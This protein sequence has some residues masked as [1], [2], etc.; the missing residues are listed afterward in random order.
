MIYIQFSLSVG[1]QFFF[2]CCCCEVHKAI[3]IVYLFICL[4]FKDNGA[5]LK[6]AQVCTTGTDT[7]P[8]THTL[9]THSYVYCTWWSKSFAISAGQVQS[10]L[11]QKPNTQEPHQLGRVVSIL[12]LFVFPFFFWG[13][14]PTASVQ[15]K[16]ELRAKQLEMEMEMEYLDI[17]D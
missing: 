2:Y 1:M 7:Y 5:K 15:N 12:L 4:H 3:C 16:R 14:L 10:E 9:T 11:Q 17:I 8:H 6:A 13:G